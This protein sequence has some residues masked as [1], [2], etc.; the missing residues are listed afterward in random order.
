VSDQGVPSQEEV[1]GIV[2]SNSA[3]EIP[4]IDLLLSRLAA[5]SGVK[6][7]IIALYMREERAEELCH[8]LKIE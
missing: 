1:G 6:S 3:G 8:L 7:L 5:M 2:V 4:E